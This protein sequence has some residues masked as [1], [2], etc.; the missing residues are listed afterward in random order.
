MLGRYEKRERFDVDGDISFL[1]LRQQGPHVDEPEPIPSYVFNNLNLDI[2]KRVH[3]LHH[4]QQRD[5]PGVHT[6]LDYPS[7]MVPIAQTKREE[8]AGEGRADAHCN[9]YQKLRLFRI[10]LGTV[11]LGKTPILLVLG[12]PAAPLHP[13]ISL[14]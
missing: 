6:L 9:I 10:H 4:R 3:L 13:R 2:R 5:V 14:A 7:P 12:Q 1:S 11:P 8:G